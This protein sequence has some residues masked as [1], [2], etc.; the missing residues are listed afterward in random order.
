M[1][2]EI[3]GKEKA[4][5]DILPLK[6]KDV[7]VCNDCQEYA[8]VNGLHV[9]GSVMIVPVKLPSLK[10]ALNEKIYI[11]PWKKKARHSAFIAF[12]FQGAVSYVGMVKDIQLKVAKEHLQEILPKNEEWSK[13]EYYTVYSLAFVDSLKEPIVRGGCPNIQGKITSSFKKFICAKCFCDLMR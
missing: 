4:E 13:R 10:K 6:H 11:R 3:C 1:K 12:C 8:V 2:C 9:L 7:Y 5:G